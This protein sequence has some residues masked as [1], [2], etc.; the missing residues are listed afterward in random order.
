MG[1]GV[2]RDDEMQSLSRLA[3]FTRALSDK[4]YA[5]APGRRNDNYPPLALPWEEP[6]SFFRSLMPSESRGQSQEKEPGAQFIVFARDLKSFAAAARLLGAAAGTGTGTG[7]FSFPRE[8]CCTGCCCCFAVNAAAMVLRRSR[9][10]NAV[11][12]SS[13]CF[14]SSRVGFGPAISKLRFCMKSK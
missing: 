3:R 5:L 2:R 1:P 13:I 14:C 9:S 12:C 4:R 8:V 11:Y 6:N 7:T 10:R